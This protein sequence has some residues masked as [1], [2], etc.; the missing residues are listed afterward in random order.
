MFLD[1]FRKH[2]IVNFFCQKNLFILNYIDL[3]LKNLVK[4]MGEY[5]I[6][7]PASDGPFSL[8]RKTKETTGLDPT[9][10]QASYEFIQREH[11]ALAEASLTLIPDEIP[12]NFTPSLRSQQLL[13]K[14]IESPREHINDTYAT[15]FLKYKLSTKNKGVKPDYTVFKPVNKPSTC[16]ER[17]G[18]CKKI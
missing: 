13:A 17:E 15:N 12:Y 8:L 4:F 3:P 10:V 9:N 16:S 7:E 11:P 1:V 18:N 6:Y 2:I 14:L 5:K